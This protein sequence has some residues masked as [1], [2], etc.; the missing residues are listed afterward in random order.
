VNSR[1]TLAIIVV[2][3]VM[4]FSMI[5]LQQQIQQNAFALDDE[6]DTDTEQRLRQKNLGSGES[7]NFSCA[8]NLITSA[9]D[10]IECI[11]SGPAAP[12]PPPPQPFTISGAVIGTFTCV[13]TVSVSAFTDAAGEE[14]GTVTG[15]F[16]IN[17]VNQGST[18]TVSVTG[19]TTDGNTFSLSGEEGICGGG[20]FTV[21]G[22][23]GTDVA[24]SYE[25]DDA[26]GNFDGNVDCTLA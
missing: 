5:P 15:A 24:V 9:S 25:E 8:E 11:P 20:S 14:D 21:S 13:E 18:F 22:N 4:T 1:I 19:G 23:C 17:V 7:T 10:S 2:F 6:S 26:S 3:S 16:G 12:T